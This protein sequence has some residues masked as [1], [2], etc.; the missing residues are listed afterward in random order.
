MR[1]N[2]ENTRENNEKELETIQKGTMKNFLL[3]VVPGDGHGV[4]MTTPKELHA[5]ED[6]DSNS[7]NHEEDESTVM[8]SVSRL[9]ERR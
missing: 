5:V 7:V 2:N 6:G 8:R 1:E 4:G 9:Q 3:L